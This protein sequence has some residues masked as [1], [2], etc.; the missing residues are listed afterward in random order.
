MKQKILPLI[1]LSSMLVCCIE[2]EMIVPSFP[3]MA[4]EFAVT[5]S[6]IQALI[7]FNLLGFS[8]AAL[9]YGPL[10]DIY[11]RRKIMLIG[12][13]IML[14]GASLCVVAPT[15]S[16]LY[17]ARWIQGLGAA[18]SAVVVFAILADR[19]QG[20]A[21]IK[22]LSIFN[23]VFT[24]AMACAPIIGGLI[25]IHYGWR[26]NYALI[27]LITSI[28]YVIIL[29]L[30][31]E[32]NIHLHKLKS[33]DLI[34]RYIDL[35]CN[36]NFLI[37]A[38]IPSL[39]YAGYMVFVTSSPFLFQNHWHLS[40]LN[41][42]EHLSFI[43]IIFVITS[44][45]AAWINQLLNAKTII[46]I[47]SM[48]CSLGISILTILHYLALTTPNNVT[49]AM[50]LYSIGFALLYPIIFAKSLTILSQYKGSALA[51]IM[52]FRSLMIA[53]LLEIAGYCQNMILVMDFILFL[54][55]ILTIKA[56]VM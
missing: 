39:L 37:T 18:T 31:P 14:A 56:N 32:T 52:S 28:S 1:L 21:L 26:G 15:I 55:V 54:I 50:S 23:A 41:Y 13:G 43:I 9:F 10:S 22:L 45:S 46:I 19:Y 53:V 47:A 11:G 5:N 44:L 51:L 38:T 24:I 4:L 42:T 2:V 35:L 49:F 6:A 20:V 48:F 30:L 17:L 36:K 25:T 40:L 16:M 7:F 3:S 27:A 8:M 34:Q 29:V 12:N 33:L